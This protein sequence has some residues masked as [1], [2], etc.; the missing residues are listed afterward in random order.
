MNFLITLLLKAT[1]FLVLT[2]LLYFAAR[3]ASASLRHWM[4]SLSL[5]GL[6]ALPFSTTMLPEWKVETEVAHLLPTLSEASASS[7]VIAPVN[8]PIE[9]SANIA[10]ETL[11]SIPPAPDVE[12]QMISIASPVSSPKL[13]LFAIICSIWAMGSCFFLFRLFRG[14][15]STYRL[16]QAATPV[17]E[18]WPQ[19]QYPG[20]R[21]AYHPTIKSPMTWGISRPHILLPELA[22]TWSQETLEVVLLHEMTHIKRQDYLI[23]ILS[24]I[25][26][27][28]YWFHPLVWWFK[29]WQ[30]VEREK[31]CDEQV[32]KAG[33]A[34]TTYAEQLVQV[35]KYLSPKAPGTTYAIPMASKSQIK[36][37]IVSILGF[38]VDGFFFSKWKQFRW[39]ATYILA[40][41]VLASFTPVEP[42]QIMEMVDEHHPLTQLL[43]QEQ[44]MVETKI[45]EEHASPINTTASQPLS[46]TA[47]Q[48]F[49]V[50]Q[51]PEITALPAKEVQLNPFR[52]SFTALPIQALELTAKV[53]RKA[54]ASGVYGSWTTGKSTF[55]VWA[56][57]EYKSLPDFPYLE[58]STP[59]S[60]III[61]ERRKN[62]V[63]L[64]QITK[65]PY[66]GGIVVD[67]RDGK[68]NAW[69]GG[70]HTG[71]PIYLFFI[72]EEW[73][74]FGKSKR[75]WLG[76]HLSEI[77]NRLMAAPYEKGWAP[78]DA[79]DQMIQAQQELKKM[80][81]VPYDELPPNYFESLPYWKNMRD[82]ANPPFDYSALPVDKPSPSAKTVERRERKVGGMRTT[83]SSTGGNAMNDGQKFGRIISHIPSGAKAQSFN[84][85]LKYNQF[86]TLHFEL[87]LYQVKDNA[88]VAK[89]HEQPV[90]I[91]AS[92]KDWI[93]LALD[94]HDIILTEEVLVILELRQRD[95]RKGEGHI[96]FSQAN[97]PYQNFHE[98][99]GLEWGFWESNFAFYLDIR[100]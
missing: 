96:L 91:A 4:I 33:L 71:D 6:L 79:S 69:N 90:S 95:G 98:K 78:I 44:D 81:Y 61:R 38:D 46:P 13:S 18:S 35:A 8:S 27:S 50:D 24:W 2:S 99:T 16:T 25:S 63:Y 28:I 7:P 70:Y 15:R 59:E 12:L 93:S 1:L 94:E 68:I 56:I 62:K 65:A 20:V 9:P 32:L 74:F 53:D 47:V 51:L 84:F 42:I 5:I 48:S 41:L 76:E 67:W 45:A 40:L 10:A 80:H 26:L 14:M 54:E 82:L 57:G 23:H 66:D 43:K 83:N 21:I 29:R 100:P 17:P 89:L 58:V 31:A 92:G 19:I 22:R 60:M 86:E 11:Q 39:A 3:K 87:Q 64:M 72:D 97:G 36:G 73:K 37:R 85:H 34:K 55:E 52:P 75:R 77:N 49:K 30:S 88:V